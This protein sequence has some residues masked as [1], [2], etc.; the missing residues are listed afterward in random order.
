VLWCLIILHF[1][2]TYL[3][4]HFPLP[5]CINA[6]CSHSIDL[7]SLASTQSDN[8][9]VLLQLGNQLITLLDHIGVPESNS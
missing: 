5:S 1:Y 3:S 8:L 2:G 9:T 7:G 4:R 6:F